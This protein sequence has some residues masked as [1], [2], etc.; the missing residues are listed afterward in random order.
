MYRWRLWSLAEL[1]DAFAEAGFTDAR[2]WQ[3]LAADGLDARA[4]EGP[5][6]L[7]E[8]WIVCT[9]ARPRCS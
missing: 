1:A 3:E 4:V 2:T 5:E 6:E 9:S 7:G 8:N